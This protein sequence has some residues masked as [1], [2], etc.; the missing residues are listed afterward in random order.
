MSINTYVNV[1]MVLTQ[2]KTKGKARGEELKKFPLCCICRG[3]FYIFNKDTM[4]NCVYSFYVHSYTY[5]CRCRFHEKSP[6]A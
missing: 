4:N 6:Y 3:D 2:A 1:K 5:I